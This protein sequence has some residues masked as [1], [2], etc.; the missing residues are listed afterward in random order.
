MFSTRGSSVFLEAV[1][2]SQSFSLVVRKRC[3]IGLPSGTPVY[4]KSPKPAQERLGFAVIL[5]TEP[6]ILTVMC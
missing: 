3:H 5:C 6:A 2:F 1:S 4:V